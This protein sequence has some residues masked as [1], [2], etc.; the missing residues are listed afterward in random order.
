MSFCLK[1][2]TKINALYTEQK[3]RLRTALE[4]DKGEKLLFNSK[5]SCHWMTENVHKCKG[6]KSYLINNTL[7]LITT[8]RRLCENEQN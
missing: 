6:D 3:Q 1:F 4:K 2:K 7:S 8:S 5:S